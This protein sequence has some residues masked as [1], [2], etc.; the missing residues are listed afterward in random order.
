MRVEVLLLF[1]ELFDLLRK[2][3]DIALVEI[4]RKTKEDRY[5]EKSP[6]MLA[7]DIDLS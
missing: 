6:N 2:Q 3:I 4:L 5:D 7:L 1:G